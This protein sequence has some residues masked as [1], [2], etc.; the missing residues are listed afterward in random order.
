M[1]SIRS[2]SS[3]IKTWSSRE[4]H[5]V[6]LS[7]REI[8]ESQK[9]TKEYSDLQLERE[10]L[11]SVVHPS[12]RILYAVPTDKIS[13]FLMLREHDDIQIYHLQNESSISGLLD[14]IESIPNHQ[15]VKMVKAY[16]NPRLNLGL[17]FGY[18]QTHPNEQAW[19]CRKIHS[20]K[21]P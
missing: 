11:L 17:V 15:S 21:K 3:Q 4:L 1:I 8:I 2:T 14:V 18:T 16:F 6:K 20:G 19:L 7:A 12:T 10:E 13:G 9:F 5:R